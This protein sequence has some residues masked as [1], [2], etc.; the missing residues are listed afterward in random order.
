MSHPL[1][2]VYYL[3]PKLSLIGGYACVS[4]SKWEVSGSAVCCEVPGRS[5]PSLQSGGH[6]CLVHAIFPCLSPLEGKI[7]NVLAAPPPHS[8]S[9]PVI[10]LTAS[11]CCKW[12][13][14]HNKNIA[15]RFP[16]LISGFPRS[17]FFFQ[18][19]LLLPPD[20][21]TAHTFPRRREILKVPAK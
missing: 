16:I 18:K 19:C 4:P 20:P 3:M 5:G 6:P 15:E 10:T 7:S 2:S 11:K 14:R 21:N 13:N 17:F 8:Q 1:L 12:L 9:A